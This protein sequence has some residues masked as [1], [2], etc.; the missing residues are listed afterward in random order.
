MIAH[1]NQ[2]PT[3]PCRVLLIGARGFIGAAVRRRLE[4]EA[5]PMNALTSDDIDLLEAGA[6][7]PSSAL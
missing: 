7:D 6:L 4:M 5:V 3:N 1:K 2:S